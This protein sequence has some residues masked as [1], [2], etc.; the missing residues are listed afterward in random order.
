MANDALYL[1]GP[2]QGWGYLADHGYRSTLPYP[3]RS[4]ITAFSLRRWASTGTIAMSR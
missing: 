4:G 2:L 1:D 3:T